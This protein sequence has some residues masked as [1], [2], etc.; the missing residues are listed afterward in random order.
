MSVAKVLKLDE[1][2]DRRSY[3]LELTRAL[4]QL[5]PVRATLF[6][7]L[8]E[9]AGI[10]GADRVGAVWVDEYGPGLVHPHVVLDLLADRPRRVFGSEPLHRAWDNGVPGAYDQAQDKEE[11]AS[12]TIAVAL[13]SDG[14]RGWFIV[15]ESVARRAAFEA[16]VRD[17]LMFVVGECSAIVMHRD[18]DHGEADA[19]ETRFAGWKILEDLEGVAETDAA[20]GIISR[21]FLV[22]RLLRTMVDEELTMP[23]DRVGEQVARIRDEMARTALTGDDGEGKTL[24]LL[25]DACASGDSAEVASRALSLGAHAEKALHYNGALELYQVGYEIAAQ[26]GVPHVA[27]DAARRSGRVFRRQAGWRD[28]DR[29]YEIALG[30]SERVGLHDLAARALAGMALGKRERGNLPAAREGLMDAE[31]MAK[32]S[33]DRETL[34]SIYHDLMGVE[35]QAGDLDAALQHGWKAVNTYETT[36]SRTR[37]MAGLASALSAAGDLQAAEDAYTVVLHTSDEHYYLVYAHDALG[38]IA[39]RRGDARMFA[40]WSAR[41]DALDW[42]SGPRGAKAE[43][44]HY[45]GLSYEALGMW[46]EARSWFERSAHFAAEYGFHRISFETE[47]ALA[48]LDS[49]EASERAVEHAVEEVSRSTAPPVVRD[50]LRAMRADLVGAGA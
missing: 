46:T 18:L 39:A 35:Q 47:T 7:H 19:G 34:G 2:R 22:G 27:V 36:A 14:S 3:R 38:H 42:E 23:A 44:L 30:I 10:T 25:L 50:G 4:N 48:R 5:E 15:A 29:W 21:R 49:E 31:R 16:S 28:A 20:H 11:N 1:Y 41:C 9:I 26:I 37:G 17:R 40:E 13:G 8:V 45:R 32:L 43:I 12:N 33:E 6:E 24:D